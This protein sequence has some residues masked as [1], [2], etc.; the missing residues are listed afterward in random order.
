MVRS[1]SVRNINVLCLAFWVEQRCTRVNLPRQDNHSIDIPHLLQNRNV[2]L[3][4]CFVHCSC[5]L[6]FSTLSLIH[7]LYYDDGLIKFTFCQTH[8][9]YKRI[10]LSYTNK[11]YMMIKGILVWISCTLI[12]KS[13][14]F[15]M[16]EIWLCFL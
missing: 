12:I 1:H 13:L 6:R 8:I 2:Q 5:F 14:T 3:F 15:F 10:K 16:L 9:I 7:L 4:I 11:G